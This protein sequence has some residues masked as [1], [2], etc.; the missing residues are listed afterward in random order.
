VEELG[1]LPVIIEQHRDGKLRVRAVLTSYEPAT[2][3]VASFDP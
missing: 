1:Y 2:E 3:S